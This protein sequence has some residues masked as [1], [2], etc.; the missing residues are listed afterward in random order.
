M[1]EPGQQAE[2]LAEWARGLEEKAQRYGQLREQLGNTSITETSSDQAVRVTVD[3]NGVPTE[4]TVTNNARRYSPEQITTRLNET[5]RRAHARL[6]EEVAR[7]TESVVGDDEAANNILRSYRE[8]FPEVDSAP[9]QTST[10]RTED[11]DL[12]VPDDYDD[13]NAPRHRR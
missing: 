11:M 9:E 1:S 4:L 3:S 12:A 2:E 8:R 5:M 7:L 10:P 13:W 6:S